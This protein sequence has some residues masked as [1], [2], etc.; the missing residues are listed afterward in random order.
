MPPASLSI[1]CGKETALPFSEILYI[2]T[3]TIHTDTTSISFAGEHD[4]TDEDRDLLD[5]TYG[6]SKEHPPDLKQ[7]L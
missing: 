1:S 5:I 2:K 6:Y 3:R 7:F 4:Q